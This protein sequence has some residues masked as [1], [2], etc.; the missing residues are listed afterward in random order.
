MLP[1]QDIFNARF[2][3]ADPPESVSIFGPRR[4][5]GREYILSTQQLDIFGL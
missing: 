4:K 1:F 5:L 3:P 2:D